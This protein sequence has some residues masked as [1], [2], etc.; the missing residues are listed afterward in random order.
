MIRTRRLRKRTLV[1][2]R[3]YTGPAIP[4][5]EHEC[6]EFT[7]EG[8]PDCAQHLGN[9]P[10]AAYLLSLLETHDA[11]IVHPEHPVCQIVL[12]NIGDDPKPLTAVRQGLKM[13][14]LWEALA[15]LEDF[16]IIRSWKIP[17]QNRT[18]VVLS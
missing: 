16:G 7:S 11:P 9:L 10:Y 18:L 15:V 4:C 12:S 13:G 3:N 17:R 6:K 14:R 8:K 2:P 1:G 5:T